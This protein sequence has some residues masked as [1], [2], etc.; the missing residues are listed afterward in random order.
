[1]QWDNRT[2]WAGVLARAGLDGWIYRGVAL[3]CSEV[4]GNVS[5]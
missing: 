5:A 1:M 2:T 3:L 4:G